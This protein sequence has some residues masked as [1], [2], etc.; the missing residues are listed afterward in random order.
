MAG[1]RKG[2]EAKPVDVPHEVGADRLAELKVL[3]RSFVVEQG[4]MRCRSPEQRLWVVC[5]LP[6]DKNPA[7]LHG[8]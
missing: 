2:Q 5:D 1:H 3:P 4:S 8:P 7:N 6:A